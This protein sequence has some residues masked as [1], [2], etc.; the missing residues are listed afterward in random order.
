MST[1]PE[2]TASNRLRRVSES[3]PSPS[4]PSSVPRRAEAACAPR[5]ARGRILTDRLGRGRRSIARVAGPIDRNDHE[6]ADRV[7]VRR[8]ECRLEVR[9]IGPGRAFDPGRELALGVLRRE[10]RNRGKQP[11]VERIG[12]AG[13]HVRGEDVARPPSARTRR[14]PDRASPD[15]IPT[16]LRTRAS[17]APAGKRIPTRASTQPS[18]SKKTPVVPA[19]SRVR[20]E[21]ASAP[22]PRS[23]TTG[24]SAE[25][26]ASTSCAN[27]AAARTAP[28]WVSPAR[29]SSSA[30][31]CASIG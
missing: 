22:A 4:S 2:R 26:G 1:R 3:K 29:R 27:A 30:F 20:S 11:R 24:G 13:G 17:L 31:R 6:P 16:M 23:Q 14:S 15:S 12:D 7:S 28:A 18:N 10:G 9:R 25:T 21:R 5:A 19:S 8:A